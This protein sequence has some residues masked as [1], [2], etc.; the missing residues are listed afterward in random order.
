[1]DY[2]HYT[3]YFP[4]LVCDEC[5]IELMQVGGQIGIST[6]LYV[7]AEHDREAHDS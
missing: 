4:S 5:D 3:I 2:G 6:I 1:M 7:L